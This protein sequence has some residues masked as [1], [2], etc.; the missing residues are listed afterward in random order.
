MPVNQ[1]YI[2][3]QGKYE[4]NICAAGENFFWKNERNVCAAGENF[5]EVIACIIKN[6]QKKLNLHIPHMNP[7]PQQFWIWNFQ[8]ENF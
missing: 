8:Y 4:R 2:K 7:P 6:E 5:F 1:Y 3:L